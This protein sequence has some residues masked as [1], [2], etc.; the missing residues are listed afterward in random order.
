MTSLSSFH[1]SLRY[2]P[3]HSYSHSSCN[4]DTACE[5]RALVIGLSIGCV[6]L[7]VF[8]AWYAM[9]LYRR[10]NM[11]ETTAQAP[12]VASPVVFVPKARTAAPEEIAVA[13][14]VA[15]SS[16]PRA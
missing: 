14:P 2:T 3:S 8:I 15:A 9:R 10:W 7:V 13:V 4:G 5:N 11:D 12:V 6:I 16:V 1:R